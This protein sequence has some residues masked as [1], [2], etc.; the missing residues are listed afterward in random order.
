[1]AKKKE[2]IEEVSIDI[3]DDAMYN[4]KSNGKSKHMPKDEVYNISGTMLKLF[5]SKGYGHINQ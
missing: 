1:M 2:V 3:K 5:I 4:F